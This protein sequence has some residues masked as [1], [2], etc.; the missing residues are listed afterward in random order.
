MNKPQRKKYIWKYSLDLEPFLA[1]YVYS[2]SVLAV[3]CRKRNAKMCANRM[4]F[5]FIC[6]SCVFPLLLFPRTTFNIFRIPKVDVR[7]GCMQFVC[8]CVWMW[9]NV[10]ASMAECLLLFFPFYIFSGHH[11]F[12]FSMHGI[13]IVAGKCLVT[14]LL[15]K[16]I[17]NKNNIFCDLWAMFN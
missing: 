5:S 16:D 12:T 17:R 15:A 11:F 4:V 14:R 3:C 13:V 7:C 10:C 1:I 9:A 2:V 6:L 8:V